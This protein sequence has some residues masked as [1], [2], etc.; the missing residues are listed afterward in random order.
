MRSVCP[1]LRKTDG[2][3]VCS[4]VNRNVD[5]AAWYCLAD[6]MSCPIYIGYVRRQRTQTVQA[7]PTGQTQAVQATAEVKPVIA[8]E[9]KPAVEVEDNIVS[10]LKSILD[11]M[12]GLVKA[13]NDVWNEYQNRVNTA[14]SDLDSNAPLIEYYFTS[15]RGVRDMLNEMLKELEY[16][17]RVNM[18][19]QESYE[20]ARGEIERRL[21]S[22][23]QSLSELEGL[24]RNIQ[25]GIVTHYR[26]VISE[27]TEA[28]KVKLSLA[29]LEELY[30]S[31]KVSREVYEK[32]KAEL[33]RL[34]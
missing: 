12:Q 30:Q 5:P 29:K 26:R 24:Y 28:A 6:Y 2:G 31:G 14:K 13:L 10:K 25:E 20:K 15:L 21:S 17:R 16:R 22:I 27:S 9:A 1:L 11:H 19:D 34:G 32:I 7:A 33:S 8:Q 3:Y 18:I 23:N 4:A